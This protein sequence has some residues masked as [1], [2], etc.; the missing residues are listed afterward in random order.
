MVPPSSRMAPRQT[1]AD[2]SPLEPSGELSQSNANELTPLAM[3]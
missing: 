1:F 3:W 2:L